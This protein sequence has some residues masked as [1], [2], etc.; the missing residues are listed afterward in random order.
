MYVILLILT[1]YYLHFSIFGSEFSPPMSHFDYTTLISRLE[2]KAVIIY[3]LRVGNK[4]TLKIKENAT[5]L[6][7][8]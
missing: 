5:R 3:Y 2:S 8:M 1:K 4:G 6:Q 7:K